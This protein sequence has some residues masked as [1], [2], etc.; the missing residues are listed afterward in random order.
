MGEME[1]INLK[2]RGFPSE[3]SASLLTLYADLANEFSKSQNN[4]EEC[5][6]IW[7]NNKTEPT[8][9]SVRPTAAQPGA[10]NAHTL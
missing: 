9:L 5:T 4:L 10:L 8:I 2:P 1:Q 7:R 6:P 3:Y